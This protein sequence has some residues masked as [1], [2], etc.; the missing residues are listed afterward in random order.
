[1]HSDLPPPLPKKPFAN[2]VTYIPL[3]RQYHKLPLSSL[4]PK[5]LAFISVSSPFQT[6]RAFLETVNPSNDRPR[7]TVGPILSRL[8][9]LTSERRTLRGF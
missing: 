4:P 3:P 8:Y 2:H 7:L 6:P 1:M 5:A 9:P